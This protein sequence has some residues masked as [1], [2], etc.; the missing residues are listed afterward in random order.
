[1]KASSSSAKSSVWLMIVIIIPIVVLVII[2]T[3]IVYFMQGNS[4][5]VG[6]KKV[7]VNSYPLTGGKCGYYI[8]DSSG[9]P[10]DTCVDDSSVEKALATLPQSGT[11]TIDNDVLIVI[12]GDAHT[13][14]QK[15]TA[16]TLEPDYSQ[17]KVVIFDSISSVT[18][19]SVQRRK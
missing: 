5:A 14:S 4:Q 13:I 10:E 17:T 7:L 11:S 19:S 18:E 1:M 16:A 3:S 15:R 2:I 12:E 8:Y 9:R 6:K